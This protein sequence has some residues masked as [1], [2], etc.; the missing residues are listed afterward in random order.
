MTRLD[1]GAGNRSAASRRTR[2][3]RSPSASPKGW[4]PPTLT[5]LALGVA[6]IALLGPLA[7]YR[8][9]ANSSQRGE[10]SS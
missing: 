9:G 2:P 8:A 3:R 7:L 4:V 10:G 5:A 1:Q 6:V